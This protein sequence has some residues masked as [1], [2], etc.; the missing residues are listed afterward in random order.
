VFIHSIS[1]PDNQYSIYPVGHIMQRFAGSIQGNKVMNRGSYLLILKSES[2][3]AIDIGQL[4][5]FKFSKEYLKSYDIRLDY[6]HKFN[7]P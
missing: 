6:I 1:K 2:D 5:R 4:G 3:K 7:L